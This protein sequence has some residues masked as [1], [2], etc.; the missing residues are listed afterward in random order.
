MATV[1]IAD[2]RGHIKIGP[3]GLYREIVFLM[4][5]P[6]FLGSLKYA[7]ELTWSQLGRLEESEGVLVV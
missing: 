5:D 6:C 7:A 3:I 2:S 1:N 4:W